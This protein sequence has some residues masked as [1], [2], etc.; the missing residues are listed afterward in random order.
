MLG[1]VFWLNLRGLTGAFILGT[2]ALIAD[3]GCLWLRIC[4][5]RSRGT[6]L[7]MVAITGG[8]LARFLNIT[9]FM[10]IGAWWLVPAAARLFYLILITTPLWNLLGAIQLADRTYK[11]K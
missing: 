7:K 6:S 3:Y 9:V 8:F 11:L 2:T 10:S 1:L 5:L 4:L